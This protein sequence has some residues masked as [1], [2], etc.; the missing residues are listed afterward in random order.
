[1]EN[2]VEL[3]GSML[4]GGG[5]MVR[6]ALALSTL[7]GRPFRIRDIRKGRP[8]PGLK[9]QHMSCVEA[10]E[11]LCG[12]VV[13]GCEPGSSYLSYAPGRISQ[14]K[15]EIDI[16]TA[17]SITL[18]MQSL[19]L[20]CLFAKK[21]V[22]LSVRGGSDVAWS[23]PFDYLDQVLIPQLRR[24]ARIDCRLIRR[25]YYPR[26][27]G[28]VEVALTP[29]HMLTDLS[30]VKGFLEYVRAEAGRI[31]LCE[32]GNLM[33]IKG[34]SHASADL[35]DRRVAERQADAARIALSELKVPVSIRTEYAMTA[36][37]GSGITLWAVF[38]K[39]R[40]DIDIKN[41]IVLGADVL[42]EKSKLAERVGEEAAALIRSQIR[43]G[44]PVDEHLADNLIPF[45]GLF[46]GRM[47][48][49]RITS[50]TRTNIY[51]VEKFLGHCL[52]ADEETGI[53]RTIR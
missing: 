11:R 1:M 33:I 38:S 12:A 25:G 23:M 39:D 27:E 24:Y 37:T 52:D 32:Q 8:V 10:L 34:V 35:S 2:I 4:E 42:G 6:T 14:F 50:H 41:P 22:T 21:K 3:D 7:T 31:D 15:L 44:A 36:S 51:V 45:L 49:S 19:L 5:Q 18:L 20:P 26:G 13:E 17:G 16:G 48:T 46:G 28:L 43:T 30:D 47:R 53:V 9:A 29:K 40:E